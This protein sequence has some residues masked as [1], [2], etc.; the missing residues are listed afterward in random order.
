[1]RHPA[2]RTDSSP[3]LVTWARPA[4]RRAHSGPVAPA[5]GPGRDLA[6]DRQEEYR[7]YG[8]RDEEPEAGRDLLQQPGGPGAQAA[9]PA[10]HGRGRDAELRAEPVPC[11][12]DK[13]AARAITPTAWCAGVLTTPA[14]GCASPRTTGTGRAG[15]A[16]A[17]VARRP[18]GSP[19]PGRA[20]TGA[21]ARHGMTGRPARRT[22][23]PRTRPPRRCTAASGRSFPVTAP[24]FPAARGQFV[25]QVPSPGRAAQPG[26]GI[27]S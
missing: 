9:Q 24:R 26:S 25:L 23:G 18:S 8:Y 10:A 5:P 2:P 21:A 1:M 12:M 7:F 16:A 19:A 27:T 3:P 6:V 4:K 14:A 20:P 17:A 13:A 22:P 15:G 11:S